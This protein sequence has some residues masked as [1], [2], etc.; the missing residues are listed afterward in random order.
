MP[1]IMRRQAMLCCLR[2]LARASISSRTL[3]NA[4]ATFKQLVAELF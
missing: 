1:A 3:K 2:R 4:G